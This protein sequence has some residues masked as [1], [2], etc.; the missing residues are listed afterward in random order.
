MS[1]FIKAREAALRSAFTKLTDGELTFHRSRK[2]GDYEIRRDGWNP[3]VFAT[4]ELA[5]AWSTETFRDTFKKVRQYAIDLEVS[6]ANGTPLP[7]M[8]NYL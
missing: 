7:P 1:K 3:V 8:E 6:K 5:E 4:L 2:T